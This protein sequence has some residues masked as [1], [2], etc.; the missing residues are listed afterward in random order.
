VP[1]LC[2]GQ[3]ADRSNSRHQAGEASG[4]TSH[5]G[6]DPDHRSEEF[7]DELKAGP[8]DGRLRWPSSAGRS[9]VGHAKCVQYGAELATIHVLLTRESSEGSGMD[10]T[11]AEDMAKDLNLRADPADTEAVEVEVKLRKR[12]RDLHPDVSGGEFISDEAEAQFARIA[13]ALQFIRQN[14][15]TG[16]GAA[17]VKSDVL[18]DIVKAAVSSALEAFDKARQPERLE[19]GE[20]SAHERRATTEERASAATARHRS[21]ISQH[22]RV[23]KFTLGG[24][25]AAWIALLAL[26]RQAVDNPILSPFVGRQAFQIGW[27]IGLAVV[28][29]L[30][31]ST[32]VFENQAKRTLTSLYSLEGQRRVLTEIGT[33]RT[34][35]YRSRLRQYLS[36]MDAVNRFLALPREMRKSFEL[37]D[38]P[39]KKGPDPFEEYLRRSAQRAGP[40]LRRIISR[41]IVGG[42]DSSALDEATDLAIDRYMERGWIEPKSKDSDS[43]RDNPFKYREKFSPFDE[44]YRV[45]SD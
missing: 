29:A 24:L 43:H 9:V 17:L 42:I 26:P 21:N 16:D 15:G 36:E 41:I 8:A 30:W 19:L 2:P 32:F 3:L 44:A 31:L 28:A 40:V 11:S 33:Y 25:S 4:Q 5:R 20:E 6:H 13:L 39:H 10:W 22:A 37:H 35:F 7:L 12:L 27:F 38:D 18:A 23:P 45:I 1:S 34:D 14:R